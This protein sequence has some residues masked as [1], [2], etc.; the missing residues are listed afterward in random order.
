ML[1]LSA[2]QFRLYYVEMRR[3]RYFWAAGGIA[4]VVLAFLGRGAWRVTRALHESS[5]QVASAGKLAFDTI[6]LDRPLPQY[7]NLSAP[8]SFRDAVEFQGSLYVADPGGLTEYDAAGVLRRRLRCG[9]ELP[10]A[11]VVALAKGVTP[12]ASQ[13]EIWIGT[14]GEGIVAFDGRR[15]RQIRPKNHDPRKITALLATPSGKLFFGTGKQGVLVYDGTAI[16]PAHESLGGVS[17]TALAGTE[18]NLW[19]G[20]LADGLL[21]FTAGRLERFGESEGLPDPQVLSIAISGDG[22]T[23]WAGTAEGTAEIRNGHVTRVIA[24][25][26]FA[27]S[28]LMRNDSL[29]VGT[30]QEGVVEAQL[31]ARPGRP[32]RWNPGVCRACSIHKLLRIADKEYALAEDGLYE[33]TEQHELAAVVQRPESTLADRNISALAVDSAGR[34]WAGFFDHG[35]QI[36][37]SNGAAGTRVEDD[38]VFCVNRIV[39]DRERGVTAVATA[40]GLVLFDA[41]GHQRQLLGRADGLIANQVTDVL[42]RPGAV[43]VVATPAGITTVE[44][45]GMSSIYAFHGLVNNHVYALAADGDTTLAGTLG[46]LSILERGLVRAS[47]TTANSA[48]KHNWITALVPA[49]EPNAWMAGTYGAGVLKLDGDRKWQTFPDLPRGLIVN[50]NAMLATRDAIYAGTLGDGLAVFRR[51]T[52]RWTLSRQGLP[53]SNVT[54]LEAAGGFLYIGTD[55]GLVRVAEQNV[56]HP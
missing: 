21:H 36:I 55:N 46:G 15:V 17:V 10:G 45:G 4:L 39:H 37:E 48:L 25:G 40:N 14:D 54:A 51:A 18:A 53:S 35:L 41:T 30:I 47:Y 26:F 50:P 42:F 52:A 32:A 16:T 9:L 2:E 22:E 23:A 19:I 7:E 38:H 56:V 43:M 49:G 28:L 20:T 11:P 1:T 13:P 8:V 24:P 5:E 33:L 6:T 3:H 27:Q 29:L 31:G 44:A 34:L 12:D